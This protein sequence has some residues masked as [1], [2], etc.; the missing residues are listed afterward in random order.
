MTYEI[1]TKVQHNE[2]SKAIAKMA[3]FGK[4]KSKALKGEK[5]EYMKG[6]KAAKETSNYTPKH[7]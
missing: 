6:T 4:S 5:G 2:P 3:S 7:Q 1:K